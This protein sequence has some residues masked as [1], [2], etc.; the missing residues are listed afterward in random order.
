M[1]IKTTNQIWFARHD[2]KIIDNISTKGR[3]LSGQ[4]GNLHPKANFLIGKAYKESIIVEL[5]HKIRIF[6]S[7]KN[8]L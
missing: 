5:N 8:G 1:Y 3:T 6:H 2:T 4:L 7:N